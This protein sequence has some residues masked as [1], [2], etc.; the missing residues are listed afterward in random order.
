MILSPSPALFADYYGAGR[1]QVAWTRVVDDLETPVSAF[2]KIAHRQPY[3]FLF[4]SV[5]GGAWRGRYSIVALDPDLLWR[6]FGDR[7]EISTG[8]DLAAGVFRDEEIATLA[9][10]RRLVKASRFELA[11]ELPPMAAG[12][13]GVL[14]YDMIRLAEPVGAAKPDSLALPDAIMM[15]PS[16]VAIFDSVGGEIVLATPV[17][18]DGAD[19]DS[20]YEA[21]RRRLQG[22][23]S[24]L[25]APTPPIRPLAQSEA[26]PM[27]SKTSRAA[28]GEIV[29][30]A[31]RYIEAGDVF[32]GCSQPPLLSPV[33]AGRPCALSIAAAPQPLPVPILP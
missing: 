4:E 19:A 28:Y 24:K 23:I 1:S 33:R 11:A 5:E 16:V 15:R 31:K 20:A 10:L 17:R 3:A 27:T 22:V 7:A 30:R 29:Q 13:F 25:S 14:G 32:S 21:A 12:L 8:P 6:S 26:P 18:P 2:L 9:S